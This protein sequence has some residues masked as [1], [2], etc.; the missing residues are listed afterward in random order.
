M[1]IEIGNVKQLNFNITV[2]DIYIMF[3]INRINRIVY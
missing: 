2:Y 3:I 1:I